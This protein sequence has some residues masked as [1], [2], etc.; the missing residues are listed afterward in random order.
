MKS[1]PFILL[2]L[3]FL[4]SPARAI[5]VKT[6]GGIDKEIDKLWQK[7]VK[8]HLRD[9]LW[10]KRDIY[11][12]GH[13]LMVPLHS[14]FSLNADDWQEDFAEHFERFTKSYHHLDSGKLHKLHYYYLI[15]QFIIL[16]KKNQKFN[17]LVDSLFN[18]V[19]QEIDSIWVHQKAWGWKHPK[20]EK[21]SF[22]SMRE[23]IYW[24]LDNS[25]IKEN[26]YHKAIIDEE[27]FVVAIAADLK[28]YLALSNKN[29]NPLLND[30]IKTGLYIYNKRVVWDSDKRGWLFQP[31]MWHNHPDFKY[32]GNSLANNG[33]QP[34]SIDS[35]SEDASHAHR[36]ALWL[37]SLKNACI[38]SDSDK[39]FISKLIEGLEYQFVNTVLVYPSPDYPYFRTNNFMDGY[40]GVYR[41][42]YSSLGNGYGYGPYELTEAIFLGWWTFLNTKEIKMIYKRMEK[43]F[44]L[45]GSY[46]NLVASKTKRRRHP[47]VESAQTNGYFELI[48]KL[49]SSHRIAFH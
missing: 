17:L 33:I 16:A 22:E 10:Q 35:I 6:K 47:I 44:P 38:D 24:K 7:T 29:V 26:T 11:D 8:L 39:N 9:S 25:N 23:R 41:W 21:A 45:E 49:S 5:P 12:A 1:I 32:S 4:L 34:I 30:I 28:Y 15:S 3:T 40:N 31:G 2:A 46:L 20:R 43:S 27:F 14:S 18:I 42:S 36:R 48:C 19:Y 37:L 13:F